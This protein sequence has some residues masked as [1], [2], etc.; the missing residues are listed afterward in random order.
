MKKKI[1]FRFSFTLFS[2]ENK[3]KVEAKINKFMLF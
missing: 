3:V 2:I 1:I